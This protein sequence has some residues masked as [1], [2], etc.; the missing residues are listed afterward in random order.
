MAQW[1]CPSCDAGDGKLII[2]DA[3]DDAA[4]DCEALHVGDEV[5]CEQCGAG[6]SGR[7]L[8]NKLM[9]KAD[10]VPCPCC[11][12]QGAISKTKAAALKE[13]A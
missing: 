7:A 10:L 4:F 9:K 5:D 13:K 8:A 1:R 2:Q 11:N 3:P 6:Y 12:G